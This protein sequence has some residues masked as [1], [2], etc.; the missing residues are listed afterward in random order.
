MPP[1]FYRRKRK[2]DSQPK[3][4]PVS[5]KVRWNKAPPQ[6]EERGEDGVDELQSSDSESERSDSGASVDGQLCLTVTCVG[7][8]VSALHL[9]GL[10]ITLRPS[11][12][13]S[14]PRSTTLQTEPYISLR[15]PSRA[16]TTTYP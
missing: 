6:V 9:A 13:S 2:S 11:A 14:A 10:F 5:K 1:K 3:A 7:Y 4:A 8:A 16:A 12:E 15:T